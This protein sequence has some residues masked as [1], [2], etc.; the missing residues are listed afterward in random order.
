MKYSNDNIERTKLPKKNQI[1]E[2][3]IGYFDSHFFPFANHSLKI[4]SLT[5]L[6]IEDFHYDK[7][8]TFLRRKQLYN[9][10]MSLY[11]E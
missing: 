4:E 5:H 9:K 8:S 6:V 2:R 10:P 7:L 11:S 1:N 3:Y